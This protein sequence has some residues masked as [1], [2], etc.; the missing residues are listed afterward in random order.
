LMTGGICMAR[1]GVIG[2]G[3]MGGMLIR[4]FVE[5]GAFPAGDIVASNRSPEKVRAVAVATGIG[6]A[7]S[8]LALVAASDVIFICVKPLEVK[9]LLKELRGA[10]A[11]DKLLVSIAADVA[12]HEISALCDARVARVIPSVTSECSKG[13]SL[14]TF[15]DNSTEMDRRLLLSALGRICR[16]VETEEENLEMLADLTSCAPAFISSIMHEFAL[17][18]TRRENISPEFAELLVMETLVGTAEL[19]KTVN[20]FEEV[21]TRVA[22]KGGITEEGVKVIRKVVPSMYDELLEV[23]LAKH[24]LVKERIRNQAS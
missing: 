18:A 13:V 19:L 21:V 6:I 23:T 10:L 5:T 16:P 24:S 9:P 3:S 4:K 20:S 17:S 1:I 11:A 2:T 7:A 22:T 14:V 12:I 15:G 8:N